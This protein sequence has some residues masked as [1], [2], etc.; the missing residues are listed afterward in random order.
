MGKTKNLE[1]PVCFDVITFGNGSVYF[2]LSIRSQCASPLQFLF[3]KNLPDSDTVN[4]GGQIIPI[5][6]CPTFLTA[7]SLCGQI[8]VVVVVLKLAWDIQFFSGS[9]SFL[10]F[11]ALDKLAFFFQAMVTLKYLPN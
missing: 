10:L 5:T 7:L 2:D 8:I 9:Y 3:N 4:P 1:K 11:F 6:T